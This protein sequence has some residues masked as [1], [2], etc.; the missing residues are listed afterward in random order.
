MV[1]GFD[2]RPSTPQPVVHL[3]LSLFH[4]MRTC[5]AHQT[6]QFVL[7]QR[8]LKPTWETHCLVAVQRLQRQWL[9]TES[10]FLRLGIAPVFPNK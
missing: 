10:V 6:F 5:L 1:S 2:P 8:W 4:V 9:A 7:L 3:L